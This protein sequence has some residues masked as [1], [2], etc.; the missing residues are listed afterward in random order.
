[1]AFLPVKNF[2]RGKAEPKT[3]D[4]ICGLDEVGRGPWAGPLVACAL[5]LRQDFR[6]KGLKDS[7]KMTPSAREKVAALLMQKAVFGLG[8]V[9]PAEIDDLGVIKANN[10]AFNRALADLSGKD[11]AVNPDYLLVDGRDRLVLPFPHHT[12]IKGD[13][14]IKVIACASI[15]AK[16]HRDK[17]MAGLSKIYPGYG[18]NVHKGYGTAFHQ[19]ALKKLGPCDIHRKSFA[20][21]ALMLNSRKRLSAANAKSPTAPIAPTA[22]MLKKNKRGCF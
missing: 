3:G 18:F 16:V 7:K 19:A 22:R 6:F 8:V 15:V 13:E 9:E 5:I 1:M 17:I 11:G 21:I 14:K 20:P 12:V 10:L 4:V 2:L